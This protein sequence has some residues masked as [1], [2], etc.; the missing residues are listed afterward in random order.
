MFNIY[1]M[2]DIHG[3]ASSFN[4]RV[5]QYINNPSEND[6]IICLG[7]TGLEYGNCVQGS[8]K[9]AM[10]RFHGQVYVMRGNHDN[11]YWE[12]HQDQW[13]IQDNLMYQKKYDNIKY[14]KDEGDILSINGQNIL[15]IPGA[16]SIDKDYRLSHNLPYEFKEQLNYFEMCDLYDKAAATHIDY[17]ISHTSPLCVEDSY[18]DL[19]LDFID[20]S[21]VSKTMEKFL[22]EIYVLVGKDVKRWYFGHFHDDRN[23]PPNFTMLYSQVV[24]LGESVE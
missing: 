14:I 20:Q 10:H 23:I 19:F 11:R 5:Q 7:D 17:V 3:L 21:K 6:I 16:Y 13:I 18:K 9:K 24:K 12:Q 8:L 1:L 2:G 15:F 22:D 4:F